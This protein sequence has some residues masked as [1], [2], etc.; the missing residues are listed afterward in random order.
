ML[1]GP[2]GPH[3]KRIEHRPFRIRQPQSNGFVE[4][5]YRTL[6]NEDFR[7]QGGIKWYKALEEM[8]QDLHDYLVIYNTK[9]PHQGRSLKGMTPLCRA[10]ARAP[11]DN[12]EGVQEN[13]RKYCLTTG[14][15]RGLVSGECCLCTSPSCTLF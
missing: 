2:R 9:R 15:P 14:S 6:L 3:P 12:E 7:I 13:G 1:P 4:R 11:Q 8:Q 10:Q 5:L